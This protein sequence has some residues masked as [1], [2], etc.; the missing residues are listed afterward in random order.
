MFIVVEVYSRFGGMYW[1]L[2]QYQN[3]SQASSRQQAE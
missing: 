1:F 2:L 3:I